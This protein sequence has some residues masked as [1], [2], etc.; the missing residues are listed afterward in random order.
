MP[1]TQADS[2]FIKWVGQGKRSQTALPESQKRDRKPPA[3]HD[4]LCVTVSGLS[5][6]WC[7]CGWCWDPYARRCVCPDCKCRED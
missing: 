6:C 4:K 1:R 5:S 3:G 2:P 7:R